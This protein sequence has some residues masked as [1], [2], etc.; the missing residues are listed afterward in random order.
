MATPM[1]SQQFTK[2]LDD[3]GIPWRAVKSGWS[4][5]NREGHGGWG[6]VNG[7]LLHHTGSDDQKSM[8]GILW[9]GTG[10]LPGPLCHG[11]IDVN[12]V[13]LLTGWGRCNH[14]G[15]GDINVL[16][17]VINEDYHEVLKPK[18]N[19][20]DGNSRFY[21]FEIMYSGEHAMSEKQ[22]LTASRVSA[23]ICAY[24]G[25]GEKSVIGHGEWQVGKWDPGI[26]PGVMMGMDAVR[27]LVRTEMT[28]GAH[29]VPP[30]PKPNPGNRIH[31]VAPGEGVWGIAK[32]ELGDGG[33]WLDIVKLNPQIVKLV[34]GEP[35]ILP[36]K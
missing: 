5:H 20:V 13:V 31:L 2:L 35:L 17:H 36:E 8:P 18:A 27:V 15:L 25:W 3:W 30:P 21:G 7:V 14:A 28:K 23:A 16:H 12:G 32:A 33:R 9:D 11:G 29:P 19:T 4:T 22:L 24:H 10:D 34:P 6:P 1:T 26:K